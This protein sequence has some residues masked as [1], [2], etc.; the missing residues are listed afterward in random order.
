MKTNDAGAEEDLLFTPVGNHI[1]Q[2]DTP[3]I[4]FAKEIN[5]SCYYIYYWN[6]FTTIVIKFNRARKKQNKE[7]RKTLCLFSYQQA[8]MLLLRQ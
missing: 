5:T 4:L 8:C 7:N 3:A 6:A 1:N 2:R